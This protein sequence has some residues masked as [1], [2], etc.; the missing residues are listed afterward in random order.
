MG[1]NRSESIKEEV[2]KANSLAV[3][4]MMESE[5]TWVDVGLARDKL[6]LEEYTL[7]HAGPP[8]TWDKVSGPVKGALIGAVIYEG[9]ASTPE[10]A[11]K[12]L[13][14]GQVKIEPTHSRNAVGPMAG[15]I[16]PSMPVYEIYDQ[17]WGNRTYS[18][19]NEG[20]GKVLR[21]G[22]Y[23]EEVL[24]RLR[25][26]SDV[27]YPTL[28]QVIEQLKAERGGLSFKTII[29]QALQM[30]DDCHNRCVAAT[31]L[32]LKEITPYLLESD[33]SKR[34]AREAFSFM[35][36]NPFTSLNLVMATGKAMTLAAHNIEYSTIVTVMARNGTESGIWIS[37]LGNR[38]FSAPAPIPKG[39]Y[40]PGYGEK[41]ASGDLGDSAITE[42]AGYGGFAMAT[43]PAI[44]SWVGGSVKLA[45]ETTQKMYEITYTKH[46][47][48][49]IPY[50]NFQGT[51]TGIDVRKVLKTGLAPIINTGIAHREAGVGQ[52]GAG[53]VQF[54]I[55]IF[56]EAFRAFVDKYGV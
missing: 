52:I 38:W 46:K 44:V 35:S 51:P 27:L 10:E 28:K 37:S 8:V 20:I 6:G 5:P 2:E 16:S 33:V 32:F 7:L 9:W 43:A 24:D 29:S 1:G 22:A 13:S 19:L 55:E 26:M 50:L 15:V 4:R 17:K 48:F 18:N 14:S 42:T 31:N 36:S 53:I 34:E 23:S 30:G 21:Y 40:F 49:Q 54:P 11:E 25:W 39:V 12:L 56:K 45:L 47:Y 3:E 41:D